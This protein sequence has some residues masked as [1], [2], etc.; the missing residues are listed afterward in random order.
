MFNPAQPIRIIAVGAGVAGLLTAY[1]ARKLL[2][3]GLFEMVVYE[4][5]GI[6][7]LLGT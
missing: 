2:P 1:K 7:T 6:A 4:K 3:P 5:Y